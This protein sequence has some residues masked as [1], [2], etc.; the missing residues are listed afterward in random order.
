MLVVT[1]IFAA[2]A[3]LGIG[4]RQGR[5]L[6]S[7]SAAAVSAVVALIAYVVLGPFLNM[8]IILAFLLSVAAG[9]GVVF[10]L[11]SK[12]L[13]GGAAT[14]L[15][16]TNQRHRV[17]ASPGTGPIA[18]STSVGATHFPP[19]PTLE[20][21]EE[22]ILRRAERDR[23]TVDTKLLRSRL[24]YVLDHI[25]M[26]MASN[27]NVGGTAKQQNDMRMV[28]NRPDFTIDLLRR[29]L[30]H[31]GTSGAAIWRILCRTDF[32]KTRSA[33]V[34]ATKSGTFD[35]VD[36]RTAT[37]AAVMGVP[38]E[39]VDLVRVELPDDTDDTKLTIA[40]IMSKSGL[41]LGLW[42]TKNYRHLLQALAQHVP[43]GESE[44]KGPADGG[45]VL[46][47]A[48]GIALV[49][50]VFESPQGSCLVVIPASQDDAWKSMFVQ[51][52]NSIR[53]SE[54]SSM[55]ITAGYTQRALLELFL[56]SRCVPG[57]Q[58]KTDLDSLAGS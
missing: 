58:L 13:P 38:R 20:D 25:V 48:R 33:M 8:S 18:M 47:P 46:V 41:G 56:A 45:F 1:T 36:E 34:E 40:A 52:T 32:E 31:L 26:N 7:V 42:T 12:A 2:G 24:R 37:A 16:A 27:P 5:G 4:L 29:Q 53:D 44:V 3:G 35:I 51:L 6:S 50:A 23:H 30:S 9:A 57:P 19:G 10:A 17:A 11:R 55:T 22:E 54:I 14:S 49:V 15:G 21:L 28:L 39:E 43:V